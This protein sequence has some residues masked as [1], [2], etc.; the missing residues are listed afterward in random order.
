MNRSVYAAF[1]TNQG[2]DRGV[3]CYTYKHKSIN[4][5]CAS[6]RTLNFFFIFLE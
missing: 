6:V 5:P 2:T 3:K 1:T 4:F